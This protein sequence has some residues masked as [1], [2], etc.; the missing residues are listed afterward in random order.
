[1]KGKV[2]RRLRKDN[3]VVLPYDFLEI[4]GIPPGGEIEMD[5]LGGRYLVLT[6][7]CPS[8]DLCGNVTNVE[9]RGR[10]HVCDDCIN[11]L[12]GLDDRS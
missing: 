1:M 9:K 6:K 3:S 10:Y 8:C 11:E 4:L 7:P 5:V 2:I 12:F